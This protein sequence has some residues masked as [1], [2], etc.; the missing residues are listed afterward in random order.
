MA[1]DEGVRKEDRRTLAKSVRVFRRSGGRQ[2][3]YEYE[4]VES[5][6]SIL[7]SEP[8]QAIYDHRNVVAYQLLNVDVDEVFVLDEELA[9][10]VVP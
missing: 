7:L 6:H 2:L 10:A 4:M 9:A 1:N 5:G 8:V 3:S